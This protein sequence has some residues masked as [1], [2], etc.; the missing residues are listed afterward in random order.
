MSARRFFSLISTTSLCS[1]SS[2]AGNFANCGSMSVRFTMTNSSPCREGRTITSS[3]DDDCR[4]VKSSP[5]ECPSHQLANNLRPQQRI[6]R[7]P[8]SR[9]RK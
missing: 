9:G 7:P 2:E 5:G 3:A 1:P 6:L 8:P 4:P